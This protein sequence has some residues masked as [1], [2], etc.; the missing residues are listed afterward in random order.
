M[1]VKDTINASIEEK[2]GLLKTAIGILEAK[3]ITAKQALKDGDYEIMFNPV[4]PANVA[5]QAFHR[6]A[7]LVKAAENYDEITDASK[8]LGENES[9][10]G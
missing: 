8:K 3:L 10:Q 1:S 9:S 6:L 4:T 7:D 2:R 5:Q